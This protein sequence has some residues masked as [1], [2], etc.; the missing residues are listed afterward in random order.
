MKTITIQGI[1][2]ADKGTSSSRGLRNQG[3]VPG[4]LYGQQEGK[5]LPLHFSLPIGEVRRMTSAGTGFIELK[6]DG[7]IYTAILQEKQLHPVSDAPLH[8]DFFAVS[9]G[10]VIKMDIP[11]Q[12]TGKSVGVM[13]GGVA[14]QKMRTIKVKATMEKMPE[15]IAVDISHLDLGKNLRVQEIKAEGYELLPAPTIPVVMVEI[16]RSL[17]SSKNKEEQDR[18]AAPA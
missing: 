9:P 2:R 3:F 7:T 1:K 13:K 17:R 4:V 10:Q 6:I 8:I 12:L 16:P 15:H 14:V 18:T 5:K 11:L